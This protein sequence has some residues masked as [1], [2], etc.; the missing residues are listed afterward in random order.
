MLIHFNIR[1]STQFGQ[2]IFVV[3]N[4]PELGNNDFS[5][6]LRLQFI[7]N[8]YWGLTVDVYPK[9]KH[10]ITYKYFIVKNGE[11]DV[12]FGDDKVIAIDDFKSVEV[13]TVDT[14]QNLSDERNNFFAQ[15]FSAVLLQR[16]GIKKKLKQ[17][18]YTHI[19]RAKAP[20]LQANQVLCITG[21]G[22]SLGAWQT[23]A[24]LPMTPNGNWFEAA[25]NINSEICTYKY[26]IYDTAAKVFVSYEHGENRITSKGKANAVTI[27]HDGFAHVTDIKFKGA[28]V[29]IPIFSLRTKNSFG[30]GEFADMPGLVDWAKKIGLKL[31]Q[32]LPIND[33]HAT[34]TWKDS[35]PYAA[36][37]AFA[38]HPMYINLATVAGK[39]HESVIKALSKKQKQ[40]NELA[41][42]DYEQVM[43]FKLAALKELY[44]LEK[45]SFL[46][47]ETYLQYFNT[48]KH[49]LLPYAAFCYLKEKHGSCQ[50]SQWKSHSEYSSAN[51]SRLVSATQKHYDEVAIHYFIQ[52]HLHLQLKTATAYSHKNGIVVKGDI[53]I[54]IFR[55]SVDAWVA[56]DLYNMNEQA[57]A[58]P[59]DFAVMGQNW[60]FP[61]YNWHK[62]QEDG[63]AWWRKRFEQMSIYFDAFRIDHILG[64]FRIWSIP[65]H[66]VQGILGRFVPAL[67]L[68]QNEFEQNGI[69]FDYQRYCQPYI[70]NDILHQLFGHDLEFVKAT[71][72]EGF[73]FK[74]EFNTQRAIATFF[75]TQ[76]T[77]KAYLQ[78]TLF[79]LIS[80][81]I[82]LH[83]EGAFF[84][85]RIAMNQTS[86]FQQ[87]DASTQNKLQQLYTHYFYYRQDAFW[88]KEAMQK[89]PQLKLSTNMLIC[90]EDLGMVPHC[91]PEVMSNLSILSLEIQR[92]PK[93]SAAAFFHPNDAPYLS[94]VTPST[95]DM[96]TIRGW[97]EEDKTL[98]QQF[99]NNVMGEMGEAPAFCEAWVNRKILE[100]HMHAPAMWSIFQLQDLLGADE[101]IRRENPQEERINVPADPNHY[102]QYRMHMSLEQLKKEDNIN[103]Y[104][105]QLITASGRN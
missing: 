39:K 98:T 31:I 56:P 21:E 49:W 62:M 86:S 23:D 36:I 14:W 59:D 54:G 100:Q 73:S 27:L 33:T 17:K 48:N 61:T 104:L 52:Y 38:L 67:A 91:V 74:E 105:R 13:Q 4:I 78:E 42:V 63:F 58:P 64:F 20:L 103:G 37:S 75:E 47:D 25:V 60:G 90:G 66:A 89:L 30:V 6:A 24:V 81:V 57:G 70:T 65:M 84:H 8:Q 32:L 95:H 18:N 99:Y 40:L 22:K 2:T 28:G 9:R 88:K 41:V 69:Y 19:F 46:K 97:W 85:F 12:E 1:F 45:E 26:A 72:L 51:I 96:S 76:F 55:N 5:K 93:A 11:T 7:N 102:W 80:N 10:T 34:G 44:L 53:P 16:T 82:L 68:H 50:Y 35:Y 94:V 71:F 87:L 101:A 3:G 77:E 15:P 83:E 43:Q 79:N 29:A 92:M